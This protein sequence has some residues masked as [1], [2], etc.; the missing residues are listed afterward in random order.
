MSLRLIIVNI[1]GSSLYVLIG[2]SFYVSKILAALMIGETFE[3]RLLYGKDFLI[4]S[5]WCGWTF[6]SVS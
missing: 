5:Y 4:L 6:I 2:S 3:I 1:I